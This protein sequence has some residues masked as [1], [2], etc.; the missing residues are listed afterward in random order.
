MKGFIATI[1]DSG[2]PLDKTIDFS[3][4]PKSC[5]SSVAVDIEPLLEKALR[6]SLGEYLPQDILDYAA[7][8][9]MQLWIASENLQL[10]G[11]VV[12]ELLNFPRKSV[13]NVVVVAGENLEQWMYGYELIEQWAATMGIDEIRGYGRTGWERLMKP[14][15]FNKAYTVMTKELH[16]GSSTH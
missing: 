12:T 2:T 8:G 14:Q 5:I 3:G 6:Y 9:R 11:C 10:I 15:G 13:C 1:M 4:V 16:D 7:D